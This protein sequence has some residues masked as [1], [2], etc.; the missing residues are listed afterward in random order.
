MGAGAELLQFSP[1]LARSLERCHH[2]HMSDRRLVIFGCGYVGQALARAA[3]HA[4]WQVWIQSR[5]A[6]SLNAVSEVPA[7]RRIQSDLHGRDWHD[8]L[9]GSWDGA[10]NLVSSAGGGL[11]GYRLSYLE[12]NRSIAEWAASRAVGRFIYTSATSVYPQSDGSWVQEEDVPGD[13]QQLSPSGAILRQAELEV[14]DSSCFEERVVARLAGIYGPG[15]HLYLD[16]LR[17]GANAI[18]GDGQAWLNLI[19]RDDIV[20]ALMLL[21]DVPLPSPAELFNVADN[22]PARKQDIADWLAAAL[23]VP[24]IP[25]DPEI[26]GPRAG[27]RLSGG[28]LPDRRVSNARLRRILKWDPTYPDF[29]AGYASILRGLGIEPRV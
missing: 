6:D 5:N 20:D 15:R 29:R 10:V 27:R 14:L 3:S 9:S 23:G 22:A 24:S 12:G 21:L 19:H 8:R 18:P 7:E 4:G 1:R 16:R 25:F 2:S 17:E 28:S 26:S 11:D 13:L